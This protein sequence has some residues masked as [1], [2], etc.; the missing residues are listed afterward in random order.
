MS[1]DRIGYVDWSDAIY[2]DW[3]FDFARLRMN[4]EQS[5]DK[6]AL[7][8][9]QSKVILN[10]DEVFRE[11]LYYL[12]RL[13]EYLGIYCKYGDEFWYETTQTLLLKAVN[14]SMIE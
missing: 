13:I 10:S 11:H 6:S 5:A 8:V 9:Y 12:C 3:L 1:D 7:E 2:G 14:T 4:L